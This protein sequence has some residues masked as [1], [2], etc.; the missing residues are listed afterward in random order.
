[1]ALIDKNSIPEVVWYFPVVDL[2]ED[3]GERFNTLFKTREKW[4]LA[5]ITPYIRYYRFT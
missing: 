4:S 3:V 1:M 5:E 2:P